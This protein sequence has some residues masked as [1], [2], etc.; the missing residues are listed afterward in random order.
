MTYSPAHSK[1]NKDLEFDP[2][3]VTLRRDIVPSLLLIIEQKKHVIVCIQMR[4]GSSYASL[5]SLSWA[6]VCVF[7]LLGRLAGTRVGKWTTA[8]VAI[9]QTNSS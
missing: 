7:R 1:L 4:V 8:F 3:A 9:F 5:N 2:N 6:N